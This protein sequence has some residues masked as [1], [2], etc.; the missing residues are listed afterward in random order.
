GHKRAREIWYLCRQYSAKDAYDMGMVNTVVPLDKLEE[1]TLRWCSEILEK[2][3]TALRF[4]TASFNTDTDD[5][6]GLQQLGCDT[7]L[8]YYTTYG[9]KERRDAFME[10]RE[11][12]FDQ[13]PRF[14]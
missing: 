3:Q 10:I 7:L 13:F 11:P 6:A 9:A 14:P 1:E 5:L 2:A 12:D 8:L 4:L